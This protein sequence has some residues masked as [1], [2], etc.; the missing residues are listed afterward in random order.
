MI[1]IASIV[2]WF[3]KAL[4][5]NTPELTPSEQMAVNNWNK[6]YQNTYNLHSKEHE[7]TCRK[8]M[9][10]LRTLE[11]DSERHADISEWFFDES[12]NVGINYTSN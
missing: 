9:A 12:C 3:F 5:N 11:T 6:L 7:E 2:G 1:V 10:E 8:W 4:V